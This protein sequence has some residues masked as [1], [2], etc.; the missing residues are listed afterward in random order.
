ME[1]FLLHLYL[2]SHP[3]KEGRGGDNLLFPRD[4]FWDANHGKPVGIGS[5]SGTPS[6]IGC[7]A[8]VLA[9]HWLELIR[10]GFL[11]VGKVP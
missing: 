8:G 3:R 5:G 4:E 6:L 9:S 1:T 11:L 2:I 7:G 10:P